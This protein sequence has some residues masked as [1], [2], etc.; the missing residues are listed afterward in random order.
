MCSPKKN[1]P[2]RPLDHAEC[3]PRTNTGTWINVTWPGSFEHRGSEFAYRSALRAGGCNTRAK[4]RLHRGGEPP[5]LFFCGRSR[6]Y[7]SGGQSLRRGR[8]SPAAAPPRCTTPEPTACAGSPLEAYPIAPGTTFL[9]AGAR[10]DPTA[11]IAPSPPSRPPQMDKALITSQEIP[12]YCKP[13]VNFCL[14]KG[15]RTWARWIEAVM[16]P[17]SRRPLDQAGEPP[18]PW[19]HH[20]RS[21]IVVFPPPGPCRWAR[22]G[23]S[24]PPT[25]DETDVL[26]ALPG[27]SRW[28]D[29]MGSG[30]CYRL[31]RWIDMNRLRE[32]RQ[33]WGFKKPRQHRT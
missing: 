22:F 25:Y 30:R 14:K 26:P 20:G 11:P 6:P 29:E 19:R 4:I 10:P 18:P 5:H 31:P 1:D 21:P 16:P 7:R 32:L 3:T 2:V 15:R 13:T 27:G 17:A 8:E 24:N 9:P 28:S 23:C 33:S 12:P